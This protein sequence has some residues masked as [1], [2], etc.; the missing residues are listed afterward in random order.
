MTCRPPQ[1]FINA[2]DQLIKCYKE[3]FPES[4]LFIAPDPIPIYWSDFSLLQADLECMEYLLSEHSTWKYFIN[5]AGTAMPAV[6]KIQCGRSMLLQT[7]KV[8]IL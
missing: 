5:Q 7:G 3:T 8:V 1:S 2:V 4:V 6:T